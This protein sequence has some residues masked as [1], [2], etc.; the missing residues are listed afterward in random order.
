MCQSGT[1]AGLYLFP[2]CFADL[3]QSIELRKTVAIADSIKTSAKSKG[4]KRP[5]DSDAHDEASFR[6]LSQGRQTSLALREGD[7]YRTGRWTDEEVAYVD[8]LVAIFDNGKLPIPNGVKLNRF[9]GDVLLCKSSRLTKKMKNAKLS[10]RSFERQP[11]GC[12]KADCETLSILQ[13]KMLGELLSETSQ[14]ELRFNITK[15]WR[16]YFSNLCVQ[17]GYQHLQR[18]AF[19][20]S[21]E[22]M[23][24]RVVAAE[25]RVKKLRR[26]SLGISVRNENETETQTTFAPQPSAVRSLPRPSPMNG[27]SSSAMAHGNSSSNEQPPQK[28]R[29]TFSE[30]FEDVMREFIVPEG[31]AGSSM[32]SLSTDGNNDPDFASSSTPAHKASPPTDFLGALAMCIEDHNLPFHC[33]DVWVPSS[34]QSVGQ[35]TTTDAKEVQ[36]LH[37]GHV[38]RRDQESNAA[39]QNFGEYS[40]TFSFQPGHG[41]PGRVYGTGKPMWEFKLNDKHVFARAEGATAYGIKAAIGLPLNTQGGL[42]RMVVVFYSCS[43]L[44]ENPAL[45]DFCI[46][47]LSKY[48]PEPKWKLVIEVG[49]NPPVLQEQNK[50]AAILPVVPAKLSGQPAIN[51]NILAMRSPA[52]LFSVIHSPHAQGF[53]EDH[54]LSPFLSSTNLE[55]NTPAVARTSGGAMSPLTLLEPNTDTCEQEIVAL[56]SDQLSPMSAGQ[57]SSSL[58]EKTRHL[59]PHFMSIRLLLLRPTTRRSAQENELI[60]V[61]KGSYKAYSCGNRRNGVDLAVLLAKDWMCLK[62]STTGPAPVMKTDSNSI[63][64]NS[65]SAFS[66]P[67]QQQL[68]HPG[69]NTSTLTGRRSSLPLE[70]NQP[71]QPTLIQCRRTWD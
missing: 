45:A 20:T 33:A 27:L 60:E 49:E 50:T 61:L 2:L 32:I 16:L 18:D 14:L 36:M 22:E 54:D 56:L 42:G 28:R 3:E 53:P 23:D 13:D 10:A 15:Q 39:M 17:V 1:F 52:A 21:L 31:R 46:R 48:T 47:E 44:T 30:D 64:Y 41:L 26:K 71:L 11:Q 6:V 58:A 40:K 37:A 43:T 59:L 4:T 8:H 55:S 7:H 66:P 69:S 38:I 70:L 57:S 12:S 63:P 29:R 67:S 25:E 65:V 51:T 34:K 19:L 62:A 35:G 5:L 68:A 9:L 24:R